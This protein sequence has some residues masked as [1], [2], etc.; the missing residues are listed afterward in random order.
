MTTKIA[1]VS[2]D[3]FPIRSCAGQSLSE[4]EV[5]PNGLVHDRLW[6]LASPEGIFLTQ[7][8]CPR[9]ALVR[10]AIKDGVLTLTMA[11]PAKEPATTGDASL[12]DAPAT[13]KAP[14]IRDGAASEQLSKIYDNHTGIDQGDDVAE[15]LTAQLGTPARLLHVIPIV[16]SQADIG[17][18]PQDYLRPDMSPVLVISEESLADLNTRLVDPVL[19]NRFRPNIV[20]R[21]VEP[22]G[23]EKLERIMVGDVEFVAHTEPCGRCPMINV[24]QENGVKGSKEPLKVL[25]GYRRQGGPVIFGKY[26]RPVKAGVIRVGDSIKDVVDSN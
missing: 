18:L 11:R 14:L 24:D 1:V 23:E 4:A 19:M 26:M 10:P 22:Y 5:T 7:R 12:A 13:F 25:A 3:V 2:L 21:G 9:M 17:S 6:R 16:A 8:E 20:I 15:W